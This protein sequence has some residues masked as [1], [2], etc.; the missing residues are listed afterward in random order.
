M[1][2]DAPRTPRAA[3]GPHSPHA[4]RASRGRDHPLRPTRRHPGDRPRRADAHDAVLPRHRDPKR[5]PGEPRARSASA[6][7]RRAARRAVPARRML[8]TRTRFSQPLSCT[9]SQVP[10]AA[11]PIMRDRR[12][13]IFS[14]AD[15]EDLG[16]DKVG[17]R[18]GASK[19]APRDAPPRSHAPHFPSCPSIGDRDGARPR[20]GRRTRYMSFAIDCIEVR[21]PCAFPCVVSSFQPR[22]RTSPRISLDRAGG[23]RA[24]DGVA[25][26][27]R[28]PAARGVE[29]GRPRRRR[30]PLRDGDRRGA[31]AARD[32]HRRGARQ[33]P[34][35]TFS[36]AQCTRPSLPVLS[37]R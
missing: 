29:D 1:R 37:R 5:P 7:G 12:T 27:R 8:C 9:P 18:E 30:G 19:A 16:P 26:A 2:W 35:P 36:R 20:V 17:S 4:P 28:L 13:N 33:P 14:V 15:V 11:V 34:P 24:G 6:A 10:R 22:P 21:A 31:R 3:D 32:P 25:R 23:L